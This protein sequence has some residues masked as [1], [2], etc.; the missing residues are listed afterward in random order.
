MR[1][2]SD[3]KTINNFEI[4]KDYI[5]MYINPEIFPL[6]VVLSASYIFMDKAYSIIS[7]NPK[8]KIIVNLTPKNKDI[9]L[10]E[11][12]RDFNN[13]L[14]NYAVYNI[15]SEKNRNLRDMLIRKALFSRDNAETLK[16]DLEKKDETDAS[17]NY[18]KNDPLGIFK[19]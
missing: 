12:G 17:K 14:L 11:F 9:N 19:P 7:G 8:I 2:K 15:Q 10:E 18:Y 5:I 13:E 16:S 4:C 3:I 6:N 1:E